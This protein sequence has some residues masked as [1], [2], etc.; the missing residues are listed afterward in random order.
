MRSGQL[1]ERTGE[2]PT[3]SGSVAEGP[4]EAAVPSGELAMPSGKLPEPIANLAMPPRSTGKPSP[5]YVAPALSSAS[6]GSSLFVAAR[7]W[8]NTLCAMDIVGTASS[9]PTTWKKCSPASSAKMI[10]TG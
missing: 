7:R 3:R 6:S 2:L 1:A 8:R 4:G 5:A 10:S 9:A